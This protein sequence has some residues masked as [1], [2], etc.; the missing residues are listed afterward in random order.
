[1]QYI[2][3]LVKRSRHFLG[4]GPVKHLDPSRKRI[5]AVYG[6]D[7]PLSKPQMDKK[8]KINVHNYQSIT[9]ATLYSYYTAADCL[10]TKHKGM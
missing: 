7:T 6:S 5:N 8:G 10:E 1:M 2:A 4:N 3:I 9:I